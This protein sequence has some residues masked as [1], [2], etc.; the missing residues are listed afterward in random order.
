MREIIFRGKR[1]DTDEWVYGGLIDYRGGQFAIT[2]QHHVPTY[3]SVHPET[4]GQYT[5][6]KDKNGN[7]I[8]EGDIVRGQIYYGEEDIDT[9]A[10]G[11]VGFG[12]HRQDGSAGEFE[13]S[14]CLG[15][16][17]EVIKHKVNTE[18]K[19]VSLI[20]PKGK[21]NLIEVIGNIHNNPNPLEESR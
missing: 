12:Q 11:V 8:F 18:S 19:T 2:I 17:I 5:G 13:A 10:I 15:F 1:I 6:I 4:V 20:D 9:G 16:F 14:L 21:N 3:V 7:R